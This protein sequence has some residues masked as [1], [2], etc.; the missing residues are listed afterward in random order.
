[1]ADGTIQPIHI[2]AGALCL[3]PMV[4]ALSVAFFLARQR[5]SRRGDG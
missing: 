5:R 3:S 1:M 4:F 2:C